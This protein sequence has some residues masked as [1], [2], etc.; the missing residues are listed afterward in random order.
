MSAGVAAV[1]LGARG[2]ARLARTL[3][4]VAWAAER[5]VLDPAGRLV[6]EPLPA[7]VRCVSEAVEPADATDAPW[8]LLLEEG[9]VASAALAAAVAAAVA[10][11]PRPHRVGLEV[12]GLGTRLVPRHHPVRLAPRAG[13]RLVLDRG[14]GAALAAPGTPAAAAA[15]VVAERADTLAEAVRD[16]DADGATLAA[17]LRAG[18]VRAS[19][20]RM[21][22]APCAA[23]GRLLL[24]RRLA[25]TPWGRWHLAVLDGYRAVVACGKLW[26]IQDAEAAR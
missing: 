13:A 5:V 17:L 1:V 10:G 6:A 8:L 3:A 19:V 12:T 14:L 15:G 22:V 9:E 2:G 16:L 26:E 4:S 7:D 25:R 21:I 11:T 20:T 18:R 23:A 24:A